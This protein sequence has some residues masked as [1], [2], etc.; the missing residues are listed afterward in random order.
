MAGLDLI[1]IR[2]AIAETVVAGTQRAI[3]G[4]AYPKGGVE[5][6]PA[7]VVHP[8]ADGYVDPWGSLGDGAMC[9]VNFVLELMA[10][11]RVTFEDG[12]RVLDEMMS[13]GVGLPA[14]V[15]DA[16]EADRTLGGTVEDS[17]LGVSTGHTGMFMV[18]GTQAVICR[19][20]LTVYKQRS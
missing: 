4:Y 19:W 1:G 15:I 16:L 2:V 6:L 20:P 12:L 8:A 11:C 17:L 13:A 18:D 9:I 3:H 10:P 14:S 5:E 7:V